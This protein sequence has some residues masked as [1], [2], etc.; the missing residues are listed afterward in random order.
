[1]ME[2]KGGRRAREIAERFWA[3]PDEASRDEYMAVCMPLY[4]PKPNPGEM[5]A[6]RRALM[7]REVTRHF[8][9]GEMRTMDLTSRLAAVGVPTL[10]LAGAEDPITPVACAREIA[11]A[12][13]AELVRLEVFNDAGHGVHRD[14]PERAEAVLRG[15][16]A[17]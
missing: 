7:R 12:L 16:L 9:L 17:A 10:V 11:A 2:Q 13:P 14:E 1:M 8:V 15:F 6:R 3:S 4:N 5:A